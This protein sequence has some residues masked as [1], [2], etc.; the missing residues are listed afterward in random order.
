MDNVIDFLTVYPNKKAVEK[1]PSIFPTK[2]ILT[3]IVTFAPETNWGFGLG[4]KNLF[5]LKGSGDETRT[6]NIPLSFLYTVDHKYQF[7]S[8]LDI[9]FPQERYKLTGNINVQS[10]PSF[11][12]G[13]GQ[14]TPRSNE[15][16]YTY[17][18]V[19]IEPLFLKNVLHPF[20]YLGGGPRFNSVRSIEAEPEGLLDLSE[21]SGANGSTS[22][23][24]QVAL[25]F[26]SRDNIL[27]AAEGAYFEL[28]RGLYSKDLGGSQNF[29]LT[30]FDFRYYLQPFNKPS[31]VLAFQFTGQ[32]SHGDTPLFELGRMGGKETLRGY[33]EGRYTDRHLITTQAEWRQ[34]V[35]PRWGVVAFAGIG[36]VSS[37]LQAFEFENIRPAGGLGLRF[38]VDEKENL[39]V[40]LDFGLGQE[41][42]NYYFTIAEAF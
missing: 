3:P 1:D 37:S 22:V 4:V 11:Y 13:V 29:E 40:R 35:S 28:T 24:F 14:D 6:S 38:L 41:K 21:R 42:L 8:G 20:L 31:S 9:F 25:I 19:L 36:G 7:F 26:D 33:F 16:E 32:L 12:Y 34:K 39:N 15:E 23:G 30:K 18:Q 2:A 10:F 27:N 5:K 17:T